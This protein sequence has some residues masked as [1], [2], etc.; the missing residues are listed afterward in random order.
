[1]DHWEREVFIKAHDGGTHPAEKNNIDQHRNTTYTGLA[2]D[3]SPAYVVFWCWSMLAFPAGQQ[4]NCQ[5]A[6]LEWA[7]EPGSAKCSQTGTTA[8]EKDGQQF[9]SM[10]TTE[11]I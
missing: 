4:E 8:S 3:C 10:D 5:W 9:D 6:A 11:V 7:P 1:M 2:C